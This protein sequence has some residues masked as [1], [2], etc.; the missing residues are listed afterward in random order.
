Q[1]IQKTSYCYNG[2]S[3]LIIMKYRYFRFFLKTLFYNKAIGAAISSKFTPPN[4]GSKRFT[5]STISSMSFV[6][7]QRGKESTP[8]NDLN[9]TDFPSITGKA[10]SA[11]I[12]PKP[13]TAEPSLITAT[14]FPF[15]V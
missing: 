6:F 11:P 2:G 14:M 4:V 12:F 8:A 3:M 7:K 15:I 13:R 9:N 1:C 10:A 5:V